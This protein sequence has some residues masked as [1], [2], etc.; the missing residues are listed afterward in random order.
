MHTDDGTVI[1][2]WS[3]DHPHPPLLGDAGRADLD[4]HGEPEIAADRLAA[5]RFQPGPRLFTIM[6]QAL[7][8]R[9]PRAAS[10]PKDV[11]ARPTRSANCR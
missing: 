10:Q 11:I 6:G 4:I 2:H 3:S 5:Q 9:D 1:A 8:A 7:L